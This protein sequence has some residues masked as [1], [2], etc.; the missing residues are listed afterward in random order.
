MQVQRQVNGSVQMQTP[1]TISGGRLVPTSRQ[2]VAMAD[3]ANLQM[4]NWQRIKD[5]VVGGIDHRRYDTNVVM[6][7]TDLAKQTNEFFNKKIH[8]N[9]RKT[10]DGG[11]TIVDLD[12]SYTNMLEASKIEQGWTLIVDSVQVDL[13]QSHRDF[14]AFTANTGQPSTGAPSATDTNSATTQ[15]LGLCRSCFVQF[16]SVDN[17]DKEIFAQGRIDDFP[18]DRSVCG[19]F[20]GSTP[21]GFIGNFN[22]DGSPEYLRNPVVL[23]SQHLF[24]VIL[25]ALRTFTCPLNAEIG[26]GL[27]GLLVP[28]G[29]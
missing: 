22:Y 17:V 28:S 1:L 10:L 15:Y 4:P 19:A 27:V 11:T 20:G 21:E 6:A 25:T 14:N 7:A 23:Q 12:E 8:A 9:D 29:N 3:I 5:F 13:I 18:S 26:I 24:R 16:E 2:S